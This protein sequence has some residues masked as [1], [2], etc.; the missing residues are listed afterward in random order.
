MIRCDMRRLLDLRSVAPINIMLNLLPLEEKKKVLTEYRLRL[1]AVF[2]FTAAFLIVANLILLIP[3]YVNALTKHSFVESRFNDVMGSKEF[4][5]RRA[6]AGKEAAEKVAE[7]ER[8]LEMF[9]PV[10]VGTQAKFVSSE[11]FIKILKLK[12][13]TIRI[14][15]INHEILKDREKL[16]VSGVSDDRESLASFVETLKN[17]G[18]FT[19]VELP[20]SSYVKSVDI[21][22]SL[23]LERVNKVEK[24]KTTTDTTTTTSS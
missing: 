16:I 24:P 23:T 8:K 3:S 5:D 17:N 6:Q 13:A 20:I 2:I 12:P 1:A 14:S 19:L 10:Q 9:T 15:A 7:I 18:S 11:I 22:F 4:Q 21:E